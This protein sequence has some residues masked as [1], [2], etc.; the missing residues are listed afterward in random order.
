ASGSRGRLACED[1][2]LEDPGAGLG[3]A[4][5]DVGRPRP[6]PSQRADLR[7]ERG[8]VEGSRIEDPDGAEAGEAAGTACLVLLTAR[9][10]RHAER[11]QA[12]AEDVERRVVAALA[13][14]SG[15]A[16]ELG[17]EIRN[18][19]AEAEARDAARER[20]PLLV[21][22]ERPGDDGRLDVPEQPVRLR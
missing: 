11:R 19:P 21:G 9:R 17:P 7:G 5:V 14:R 15:C 13:D 20:A 2:L 22:Q 18:G 12:R 4:E 10:E 8:R 6:E 1:E 16:A 3:A